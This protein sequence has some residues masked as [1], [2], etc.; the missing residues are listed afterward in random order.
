MFL[1]ISLRGIML[2]DKLHMF[3]EV[4][5]EVDGGVYVEGRVDAA[6]LSD[7]LFFAT[8]ES[9]PATLLLLL[10]DAAE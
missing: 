10:L 6:A 7:S 5:V 9:A 4:E 3:V 1:R 2:L 8:D